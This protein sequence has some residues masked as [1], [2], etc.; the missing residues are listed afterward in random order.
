[1]KASYIIHTDK[2]MLKL[3]GI[4]IN[5]NDI[6]IIIYENTSWELDYCCQ[7]C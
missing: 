5:I 2:L 3:E 1:M 4:Y 7:L 6:A